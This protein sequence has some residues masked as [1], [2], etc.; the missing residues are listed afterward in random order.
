MTFYSGFYSYNKECAPTND[1]FKSKQKFPSKILVWL[2]LSSN[3]ISQPYIVKTK[4]P[5]I[6]ADIY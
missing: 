1:K 5:A 3:G 2:A 4:G 6:N